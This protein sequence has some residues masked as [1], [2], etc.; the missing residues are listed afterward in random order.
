MTINGGVMRKGSEGG[1]RGQV[2]WTCGLDSP[3]RGVLFGA[4]WSSIG[5][6]KAVQI[7]VVTSAK[8][9]TTSQPALGLAKAV[10]IA[11]AH[12]PVW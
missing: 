7:A 9:N 11:V 5:L 12:E 2:P 10:Q 4:S 6:A 3:N 8:P 1:D